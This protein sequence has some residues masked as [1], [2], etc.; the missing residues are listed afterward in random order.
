MQVCLGFTPGRCFGAFFPKL[1][2]EEETMWTLF[3]VSA[4]ALSATGGAAALSDS[5]QWVTLILS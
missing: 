3:I 2:A 4:A 5:R 1:R